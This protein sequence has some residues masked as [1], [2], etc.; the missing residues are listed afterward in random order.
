[1]P[2]KDLKN[3]ISQKE[4]LIEE[5]KDKYPEAFNWFHERG[6]DLNNLHK[7][8]QQIS[9]A[10]LLLTSVTLTPI[11]HKKVDD[12]VTIPEEPLT[13]IVDVNELTGLNEENRA[14]LIWDRYGH[15]IR[16]ISQKYE[17]DSK[18]IFATIMTESNG[19]TYA[20]RS[21]P[22]I[23]DASYG[24]GQILYGTA[25]GLGYNGSPEGLYDPETNIDLIGKYHKRTVEKYG[26]LNVNQLV[27]AYNAGNPYGN[28][29]P[30]HL[31][32]F[33][34]WFIKLNDLMV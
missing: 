10:L 20:K 7:Y 16:R 28:P 30:G 4:L 9:L 33:N 14:K 2:D 8:A 12:F 15:I 18:V 19:N 27:T 21:E 5:I 17:V 1:M 11:T 34:N 6:I 32:K 26:N 31:V 3:L 13:K 22:Q 25:K 23:N 29:Y 24:L